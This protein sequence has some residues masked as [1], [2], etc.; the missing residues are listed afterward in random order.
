M[1]EGDCPACI[2]CVLPHKEEILRDVGSIQVMALRF[3]M[4]F[5]HWSLLVQEKNADGRLRNHLQ[6]PLLSR[7]HLGESV[8]LSP[9]AH[10]LD[11][12]VDDFGV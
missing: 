3:L 8:V 5:L 11:E 2:S 9:Q 7:Q 12:G 4:L 10:L 6:C 1:E